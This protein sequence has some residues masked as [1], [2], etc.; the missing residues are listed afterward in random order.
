MQPDAAC[1]PSGLCPYLPHG[2]HGEINEEGSGKHG[3]RQ[4]T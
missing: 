1:G 2:I 4:T 3:K